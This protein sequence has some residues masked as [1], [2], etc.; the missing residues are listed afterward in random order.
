VV[1][2]VEDHYQHF[3]APRYTWMTGGHQL[4]VE[5]S[6][7]MLSEWGLATNSGGKA[8]DLGCGSGY[9][10]LAL[11]E[12]GFSVI[13]VDTSQPL[14]DELGSLASDV[15]ITV[16]HGDMLCRENYSSHGPFD[17]VVCMGDTLLHVQ[18]L[19]QVKQLF[20]GIYSTLRPGG[21]LLLSF[22][23]L[24][25]ELKGVDRA[26]PV[27]LD[28]HALMATFLEYTTSHVNVHDLLFTRSS[29]EWQMTKSAYRK[30]RLSCDEAVTSLAE[31]GFTSVDKTVE[32]GFTIIAAEKPS[33]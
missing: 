7:Q 10:S 8:L 9:Q 2:T 23:D 12:L 21:D 30:L 15:P 25:A 28:E 24:S 29:G 22:R 19:A 11:A 27:R 14:L 17:V 31:S 4:Q 13:A 6:R 33:R 16:V 5:K 32:Q 1:G 18:S 3:L 26:I 20:R